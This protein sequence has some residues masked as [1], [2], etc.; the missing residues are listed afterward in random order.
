MRPEQLVTGAVLAAFFLYVYLNYGIDIR[1]SAIETQVGDVII[2]ATS[3]EVPYVKIGWETYKFSSTIAGFISFILI[4][5]S[6][7]SRQI[8]FIGALFLFLVPP[9][10]T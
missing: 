8:L 4:I 6:L 3:Q 10:P 1:P 2:N 5:A 7:L 9:Q